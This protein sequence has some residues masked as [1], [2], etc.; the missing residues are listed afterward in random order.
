[1]T[2]EASQI[3]QIIEKHKPGFQAQLGII[4][5]SGLGKVAESLDDVTVIPYAD[6]PGFPVSTVKGHSGNLYLGFLSGVPTACLQGRVHYFEGVDYRKMKTLVRSLKVMGCN[7]LLITNSAGSL[8]AD[9]G[10]GELVAINDHINFQFNNPLVGENDDDFGDR[11]TGMEDA[12]NPEMRR[13]LHAVANDISLKLHDG[14]YVGVLGPSFETPAEINAYRILGADVV[15]MST[16]PEVLIARHCGL[17]VA[18]ISAIT[19]LA[20]GMHSENLSHEVTLKG[21]AIAADKLIQLILA[22]AKALKAATSV[23]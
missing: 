20:A 11:F 3:Q 22:Y 5:G 10:V 21:A 1:M 15:G 23:A 17:S 16:V 13:Q 8:R 19:N 12:Y 7:S 18:V 9:V 6:I 4:L 14:V 2:V